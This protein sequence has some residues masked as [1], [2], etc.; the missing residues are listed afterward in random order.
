MN[1][2]R[3]ENFSDFFLCVLVGLCGSFIAEGRRKKEEG[4]RKKEEG[5][6]KKEEGNAT[7]SMVSVIKKNLTKPTSTAIYSEKPQ[8]NKH[9]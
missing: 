2:D 9:R 1:T 3:S 5:R 7:K 8:I 4:R 6:R